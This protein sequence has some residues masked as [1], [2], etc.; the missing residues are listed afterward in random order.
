MKRFGW[1]KSK[2]GMCGKGKK[3]HLE[4]SCFGGQREK[5]S[6]GSWERKKQR[7]DLGNETHRTKGNSLDSRDDKSFLKRSDLKKKKE[8]EERRK[9]E[10]RWSGKEDC[11]ILSR[12]TAP[13][14]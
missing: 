1:N 13:P 9:S 14:P 4:K 8:G 11:V 3:I 7:S 10:A 6:S 2:L 5:K 12:Q